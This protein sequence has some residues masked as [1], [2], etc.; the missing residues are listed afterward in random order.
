MA[1]I[2]YGTEFKQDEKG[3][4]KPDGQIRPD[5]EGPVQTLQGHGHNK[6]NLDYL[7]QS[8]YSPASSGAN[9]TKE[10]QHIP[11]VK[12]PNETH[13]TSTGDTTTQETDVPVCKHNYVCF[14]SLQFLMISNLITILFIIWIL[15]NH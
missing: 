15:I 11:M 1:D 2:V 12:T 13:R 6:M 14:G 8:L 4:F 3:Q 9:G 7:S 10:I 5:I